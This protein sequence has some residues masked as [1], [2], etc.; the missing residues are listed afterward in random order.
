MGTIEPKM[1]TDN[2]GKSLSSVLFG[3]T[4]QAVLALLYSRPDES[5][6]LRQV[7]RAAGA[8]QGSVQR[9][10]RRLSEAGVIERRGHGRQVYYQANRRCSIF[11]ELQGLMIKTAG[12]GDVVTAALAP[13]AGKVIVAF[14]Y[15]SHA[16]G[17]ATATSDV[18]LLVAGDVDEVT[19]HGAV[20]EAERQLGRSVNYT[21]LSREEFT[22][23][24]KAKGGFLAR[25]LTGPKIPILGKSDEVR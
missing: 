15:G 25:V 12:L 20:R 21:L 9:E 11:S 23:R 19:L 24:R 22:R 8:G 13:I 18:D 4:R 16:T 2:V 3:K 10:L 14:V 1:G 7:V 17:T 6:Y 5:F